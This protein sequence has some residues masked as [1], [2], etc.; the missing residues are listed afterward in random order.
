[1]KR[2]G[3]LL[4]VAAVLLGFSS[5]LAAAARTPGRTAALEQACVL[6][7]RS[8][9]ALLRGKQS[10]NYAQTI[11]QAFSA[12]NDPPAKTAAAAE[13]KFVQLVTSGPLKLSVM[14]LVTDDPI[15]GYCRAVFPTA[16]FSGSRIVSGLCSAALA[17]LSKLGPGT[18]GDQRFAV[19]RGTLTACNSR[20]EWLQGAERY[21]ARRLTNGPVPR[22]TNTASVLKAL[23]TRN[24]DAAACMLR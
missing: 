14:Q 2:V 20:A 5:T 9:G 8:D 10:P 3:C 12:T 11:E 24:R 15:T 16:Y 6:E 13:V 23:C 7:G 18:S 4:A 22:G 17:T 19:E 1:M 21:P